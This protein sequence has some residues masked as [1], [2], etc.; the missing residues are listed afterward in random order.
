LLNVEESVLAGAGADEHAIDDDG[1]RGS[2]DLDVREG[3]PRME[4]P[5]RPRLNPA[6]D[7]DV[8]GALQVAEV[9]RGLVLERQC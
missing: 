6:G 7:E 2:K 1:D 3:Q 4:T 5:A 8:R 9:E